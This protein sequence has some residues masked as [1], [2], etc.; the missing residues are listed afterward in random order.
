MSR[1]RPRYE[2]HSKRR[3]FSLIELMVVMVII[4]VLAG[5]LLVGVQAARE[6]ARKTACSNN[7]RQI[8][9]ANANFE[10]RNLYF[11]PSW[12]PPTP[13]PSTGNID[14]WSIFAVLLPYLEQGRLYRDINFDQSYST[15]ILVTTADGQTQ[16][17]NSMRVPTYLCPSEP[18]DEVRLE[19]GEP[20]HYPFNY[21]AN[22]GTWFVYDTTTGEGGDGSF[23]PTSKLNGG[24]FA[25]GLSYTIGFAE[26]KAWTWYYRNKGSSATALA[27]AIADDVAGPTPAELCSLGGGTGSDAN[28][29]DT[30]HTEWVDGRAH[31]SS[32]TTTFRPNAKVLCTVSGKTYDIDWNNWQEGR[33]N[34]DGSSSPTFAAIT[35]RSHHGGGVNAVMM[36]ASSRWFSDDIDLRIWRAFST[37]RGQELIPSYAQ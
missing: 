26:V 5:L 35:A 17:L 10:V 21:A 11:P 14:G 34:A 16:R 13:V 3:A 37:R 20:R 30:G 22:A 23:F 1:S 19:A 6:A 27:D 33:R 32:F 36:D 8:G 29:R 2:N 12:R 18:R 25:D 15:A 7:L 24:H 31:H 9:L 28:L 4:A